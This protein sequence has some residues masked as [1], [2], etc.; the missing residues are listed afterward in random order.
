MGINSLKSGTKYNDGT[1]IHVRSLKG[2]NPNKYNK[3]TSRYKIG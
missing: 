3:G 2:D 1:L